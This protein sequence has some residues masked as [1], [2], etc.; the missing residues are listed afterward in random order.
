MP[1]I[2]GLHMFI[3]RSINCGARTLAA[4]GLS[5]NSRVRRPQPGNEVREPRQPRVD[6]A[7]LWRFVIVV[8]FLSVQP[9]SAVNADQVGP[10]EPATAVDA[11]NS[12]A[13]WVEQRETPEEFAAPQSAVGAWVAV[14]RGGRLV[15]D[16]A[17]S[18]GLLAGAMAAPELPRI[19][20]A[21]LGRA[22]DRARGSGDPLEQAE[23]VE[24]F[25]AA[26]LSVELQFAHSLK[27]LRATEFNRV[28]E[29][30]SPGLQG[31]ALRHGDRVYARFPGEMLASGQ[32]PDEA[33]L[34][35]LLEANIG[36]ADFSS[37]LAGG[38][39]RV[40][41]F[42]VDHL[43]Q[44][45]PGLHPTFLYRGSLVVPES[46]INESTLRVFADELAAHLESRLWPGDEPLG[47]L[48]GYRADLDQF[49]PLIAP[50]EE[51]ALA[52][53]ALA[54]FASLPGVDRARAEASRAAA[55]SV[56]S[57]L[58]VQVESNAYDLARNPGAAALIVVACRAL[59]GE[60]ESQWRVLEKRAAE[61]VDRSFSPSTGFESGMGASER[62][63]CAYV[64]GS[65]EAVDGAWSATSATA[66]PM[67]L[68]W[69]GWAEL[70]LAAGSD[71]VSSGRGLRALR[72]RIWNAQVD[73][74][75]AD[76]APLDLRGGLAY[77]GGRPPDWN[78][79][80][81]LAFLA[82][83]MSDLRLTDA[84]ETVEE[85]VRV[86]R[87][88]RFL[89]QLSVRDADR[90]RVANSEQA[91][92]GV[93]SA[94]WSARQPVGASAMSLVAVVEALESLARLRG[95]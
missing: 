10:I 92:G 67:L 63:L 93:R 54:R 79:A 22:E 46:E 41:S 78:T 39:A 65:R 28:V 11:F 73:H 4:T 7:G 69:L 66:Q 21:A 80:Q 81:P 12:I 47:M 70:N 82:T 75:P 29:P 58:A 31:I 18:D 1:S 90:Y 35:L 23:R 86:S 84:S 88:L 85:V 60:T 38:T 40:W 72:D 95:E 2:P 61:V 83:M 25:G 56:L 3:L 37:M 16:A 57:D 36:V 43:A 77:L 91:H 55:S 42:E 27:R 94:L 32:T 15:G 30:V 64:I 52:A 48:G 14:R 33:M 68:P 6:C 45:A 74:E 53:F 49:E 76:P 34:G 20:R 26:P 50:V 87:G 62:A 9:S 71:A 24:A 44:R 89:R 19:V 59:G 13:G 51:Q 8:V 17:S 5:L